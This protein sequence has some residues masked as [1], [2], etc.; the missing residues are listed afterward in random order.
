[1][2]AK[3]DR[4]HLDAA[5]NADQYG[6][7]R[8]HGTNHD[9]RHHGHH[10]DQDHNHDHDSR[11]HGHHEQSGRA[12]A[13]QAGDDDGDE[14]D[15][16]GDEGDDDGWATTTALQ[17]WGGIVQFTD[18]DA[19]WRT[20]RS[21]TSNKSG[22]GLQIA[23]ALVLRARS[24]A[25]AAKWRGHTS[26]EFS[27]PTRPYERHGPEPSRWRLARSERPAAGPPVAGR[28]GGGVGMAV[29]ATK[30]ERDACTRFPFARATT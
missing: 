4:P 11:C 19:R 29:V 30:A 13:S 14:G 21:R 26:S 9:S 15:D 10:K 25:L 12:E 1:M 27:R 5:S 3:G 6:P 16:D 28:A 2:A 22:R 24:L 20:K 8:G 17:G 7:G 18:P 23:T